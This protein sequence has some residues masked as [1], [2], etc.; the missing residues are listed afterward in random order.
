MTT[1][2][3]FM[4]AETSTRRSEALN[5]LALAKHKKERLKARTEALRAQ[6]IQPTEITG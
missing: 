3:L 1:P 5:I 6:Y 2:E 4:A